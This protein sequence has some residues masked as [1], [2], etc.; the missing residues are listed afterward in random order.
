MSHITDEIEYL[1]RQLETPFD[2]NGNEMLT[3][4]YIWGLLTVFNKVI[5]EL[6]EL[7]AKLDTSI[8]L[9]ALSIDFEKYCDRDY[10]NGEKLDELCERN[11]GFEKHQT[12]INQLTDFLPNGKEGYFVTPEV[13]GSFK[14]AMH[15]L[16]DEEKMNMRTLE[17]TLDACVYRSYELLHE[18]QNK[19]L[20]PKPFMY[21]KVWDMISRNHYDE[22][23]DLRL[24]DWLDEVGNPT[25]EKLLVKQKQTIYELLKSGFMRYALKPTGGEVKNCKLKITEDD[26]EAGSEIPLDFEVE[27]AKFDRFIEWKEKTMLVLNYSKLGQYIYKN[28]LQLEEADY[29]NIV[30]FDW[31]RERINEYIANLNPSLSQYLLRYEDNKMQA[32]L[33]DCLTIFKPFKAFLKEGIRESIIE[34]YLEMLLFESGCKEEANSKL[35]SQS[36]NKY[37]ISIVIALNDSFIF[38]PQYSNSEYA[39]ALRESLGNTQ[40]DTLVRYLKDSDNKNKALSKW[41][42]D[43][44]D[45]LKKNP[46]TRQKTDN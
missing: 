6:E 17:Y 18:I 41:T 46:Y 36:K 42:S 25:I 37:C 32:L 33:E 28:Y 34:E 12:E 5:R 14:V 3:R 35:L 43:I 27:C 11:S 13:L 24:Y 10:W 19:V 9:E 44:M 21:N 22:E 29:F 40:T 38:K 39:K 23:C 30:C 2:T 45:T 16:C 8:D 31:T 4:L 20:C 7:S 1:H 26:L 15:Q